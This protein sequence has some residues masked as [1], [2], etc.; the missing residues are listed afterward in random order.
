MHCVACGRARGLPQQCTAAATVLRP[1]QTC[2]RRTRNHL[3]DGAQLLER[4][5][6]RGSRRDK[7]PKENSARFYSSIKME[8]RAAQESLAVSLRAT[9]QRTSDDIKRNAFQVSE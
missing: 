5:L 2:V 7:S 4:F 9:F 1:Q 6:A 8:R 3:K